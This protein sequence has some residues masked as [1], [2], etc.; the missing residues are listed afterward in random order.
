MGSFRKYMAP[1]GRQAFKG[2]KQVA[3]SK[4]MRRIGK[5]AA[6]KGAEVLTG[7]A[8][9]ALTGQ[10]VGESF[11]NRT[12][13]VAL[14]TLTGEEEQQQ[15]QQRRRQPQGRKRHI[16]KLK[17]TT[18]TANHIT[19]TARTPSRKKRRIISRAALNRNSLF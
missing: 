1:I 5:A 8:V 11:K 15:Q 18:N 10:N 2:I 13:D 17:Q 14:R 7:V 12:R 9:D 3:R 4:T 6:A 19:S 16:Q